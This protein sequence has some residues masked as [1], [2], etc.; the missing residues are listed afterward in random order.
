MMNH[1]LWTQEEN[2]TDVELVG[3]KGVNLGEMEAVDVAPARV[4]WTNDQSGWKQGRR[5]SREGGKRMISKKPLVVSI[6]GMDG[7]GKSS[8]FRGALNTLA[9][10]FRVVGIG[11]QV[12]S[13]GP[14]EPV[15]ERLDIPHSRSTQIIRR[16]AKRLRWQ[17]LYKSLKLIELTQRTRIRDYVTAHDTPEIILT[18]GQPLVNCA[19]WSVARFHKEDLHGDD[20]E[21]SQELRYLAGEET[22]PLRE[23]PRYLRRAW[24]LALVN[25]LRLVRFKLPDLLFVLDLD[26]AVSMARIHARGKP[27]QAHET[28]AQLGKVGRGY[29]RVCRI[30]QEQSGIPAAIIRVDQV[31][32]KEAV[33]IVAESVLERVMV[34]DDTEST[35]QPEHSTIEVIATTMSGSIQDQ[36]KVKQ[37]GPEF[38]SRTSRPV[39]VHITDS[40]AEARAKAHNIV[41]GGGRIIVSAGGAGTFNAVLEGAHLDGTVPSDLHL[42]FLRKGSAD[43]IG[44]VLG[45]PDKLPDAVKAIVAGI[46]ADH[47]IQADILSVETTEPDGRVQRRH[48][49]GFGGMGAFGEVPRFTESRLTKIYKGILGTFLGDLGPFFVG[50]A[51]AAGWWQ[52]HRIFGRVPPA[53]L[54]LDDHNIPPE[55]WGS[56]LVL[57]GDLGPKFPLGR[58]LRLGGR[59]FR[60]IALRYRGLRQALRQIKAAWRGTILEDP[61][62]YDAVVRNVRHLILRPTE[63]RQY[64]VNVDGGRMLTRGEARISV[65]GQVWLIS[66]PNPP[67]RREATL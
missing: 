31:S 62:S 29:V 38:Q 57:N 41:S 47:R 42:A 52:L 23:L 53:S 60:V 26:P 17:S 14:D 64:M 58:G 51:L 2:T 7:C 19:A 24:P 16:F 5:V 66:G 37:I 35:A 54:T 12:L 39:R 11:D 61:E 20:E 40:D 9:N 18:D 36:R 50:L 45:I 10:H 34:G 30:L 21:L 4:R 49:V 22:I 44:K 67:T 33:Q 28:E 8:T 48:L 3:G 43:L 25:P 56:V 15:K 27:L 63:A 46:E 1:I 65:S 32:L 6:V 59:S 13:G 55:T